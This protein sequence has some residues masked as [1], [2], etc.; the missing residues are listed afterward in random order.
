MNPTIF[1]LE[2]EE[3]RDKQRNETERFILRLKR[4]RMVFMRYDRHDSPFSGF[5]CVAIITDVILSVNMP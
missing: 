4:L 3:H 5:I 1:Q 2:C